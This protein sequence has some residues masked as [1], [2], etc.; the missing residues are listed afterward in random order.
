[1]TTTIETVSLAAL[2]H[3]WQAIEALPEHDDR[4]QAELNAIEKEI[5]DQPAVNPAD[6]KVKLTFLASLARDHDWNDRI[7]KLCQSIETGLEKSLFAGYKIV[8][9]FDA[10]MRVI[11]SM[12]RA[13]SI[14]TLAEDV[15]ND[16]L[17]ALA[18]QTLIFNITDSCKNL[19]DMHGELADLLYPDRKPA[20]HL[21]VEL[22]A[23]RSRIVSETNASSGGRRGSVWRSRR[24]RWKAHRR[25]RRADGG[26]GDH[27][28]RWPSRADRIARHPRW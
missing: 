1:M 25:N 23:E 7:E 24:R 26:Y 2:W 11:E 15:W 6:L 9:D 20:A 14:F 28:R 12:T 8:C 22:M 10:D 16:N 13:L 27:Q 4:V 3:R 21:I 17:D 5:I 18:A 19:R